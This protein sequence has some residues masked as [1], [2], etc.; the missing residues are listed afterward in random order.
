ASAAQK[1]EPGREPVV[2]RSL[3]RVR[4]DTPLHTGEQLDCPSAAVDPNPTFC[5]ETKLRA[6]V[7]RTVHANHAHTAPGRKPD[8]EV[9][10]IG[11]RRVAGGFPAVI[12]GGFAQDARQVRMAVHGELTDVS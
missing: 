8:P 10:S 11:R 7:A 2:R 6:A 1:T 4:I 3:E 9:G 5:P 12:D